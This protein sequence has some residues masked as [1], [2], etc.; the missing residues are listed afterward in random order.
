MP[1]RPRRS[2]EHYVLLAL[3]PL[4]PLGLAF[5]GWW[6]QPD[7]RGYGTHEALGLAPCLPMKLWGVPCPGCGVTTAATLAAHGQV[8]ASFKTQPFGLLLVVGALAFALWAPLA[9]WR[10][11]DLWADLA[12]VDM[13][14]IGPLLAA[15]FVGAW[16]YKWMIVAG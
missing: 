3:S 14:R 11:R 16:I 12:R 7:P 9:H 1:A 13:R 2:A 5:L 6:L 15:V 4:G 10:G 8:W